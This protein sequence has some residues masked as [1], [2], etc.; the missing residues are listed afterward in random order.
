MRKQQHILVVMLLF[1]LIL[2]SLALPILG[3]PLNPQN[4]TIEKKTNKDTN[5]E[6]NNVHKITLATGDTVIAGLTKENKTIILAVIPYDP[7]KL[8]RGFRIF[9]DENGVYVV[10]N[11]ID[12]KKVDVNLFNIKYLIEENYTNDQMYP[13]MVTLDEKRIVNAQSFVKTVLENNMAGKIIRNFTII[14]ASS[15]TLMPGKTFYDLML[16]DYVTK[17]WLNYKVKVDLSD[18]VPLIGAPSVWNIGYNGSGV[19]IAILDTGIDNTHPDFYFP[20]GTSKI[21]VNADFTDDHNPSDFHGHGTH[22]ASIAAG[23]GAKSIT[24]P[25]VSEIRQLS[26]SHTDEFAR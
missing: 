5:F 21:R 24:T 6:V 15:I 7:T 3:N 12:M 9:E 14:P 19:K 8:N 23:T 26:R 2:A 13:I 1:P 10:P 4:P 17:I 22:V 18:S 11:D 25:M 20:N 16:S